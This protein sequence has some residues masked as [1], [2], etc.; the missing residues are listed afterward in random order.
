M[1]PPPMD[2]YD[3]RID[4]LRISVTDRCNLRCRYCMPAE[5]VWK[6]GHEEVLRYEEIMRLAAIAVRMGI[7]KI[8][9]T[10]GEPLVR[11][12]ILYLCANISRLEGLK[13]LSV[14]TNGVLLGEYAEKLF[15]AGIRRLN[16]SLDTL[17]PERFF[18][19]TRVDC[20]QQVWE[21][22]LAAQRV[23]ISPIKLNAVI[24]RGTNDDEIEDLA[25]L[26]VDHP[27]H[28]RFIELMPFRP[29]EEHS[30]SEFVSSD[31]ILERLSGIAPLQPAAGPE[32]NGPAVHFRLPGALG[33]IGIISP[34]THHFCAKC[35]RLRLTADG[36]LRT[37]LF[38]SEETD[39]R[40]LL[41]NGATDASIMETIRKA[42]LSKPERHSLERPFS[43]KC[44]SRPMFAIG[45]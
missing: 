23:G 39:L 15:S 13:S 17:K 7:S 34:I 21:G 36:K 44:I 33:T 11:K 32:G 18:Q 43:R 35:N 29:Q 16:I 26:T 37:C 19:I 14:T 5:G 42:I 24:L 10:G 12:D 9:I 6:L 8:R 22:I 27:F 20:F 3:R 1:S 31:E 41:R 28:V 25:R 38:A 40:Q 30:P 4:Y 2:G 45:G